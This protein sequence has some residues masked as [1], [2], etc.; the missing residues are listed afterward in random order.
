MCWLLKMKLLTA[1]RVALENHLV[2]VLF[3]YL[4]FLSSVNLLKFSFSLSLSLSVYLSLARSHVLS[5]LLSLLH[6]VWSALGML[7]IS[8]SCSEAEKNSYLINWDVSYDTYIYFIRIV[9][10]P[11]F[12]WWWLETIVILFGAFVYLCILCIGESVHF[13]IYNSTSDY[14]LSSVLCLIFFLFAAFVVV[15]CLLFHSVS[16]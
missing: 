12:Y 14:T 4:R 10:L 7:E 13:N 15:D 5:L 2:L 11:F 6:N 3:V 9:R 16:S 1:S 8:F